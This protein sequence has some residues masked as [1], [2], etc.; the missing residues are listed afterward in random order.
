MLPAKCMEIEDGK[1]C[2]TV[3]ARINNLF[4]IRNNYSSLLEMLNIINIFV[5]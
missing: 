5:V 4:A 2:K 1:Q 3:I